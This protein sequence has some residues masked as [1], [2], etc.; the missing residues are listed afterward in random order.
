MGKKRKKKKETAEKIR[1]PILLY[2]TFT[3][4]PKKEKSCTQGTRDAYYPPTNTRASFTLYFSLV[5]L[6]VYT[7]KP[8]LN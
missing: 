6:H 7:L 3:C 2:R 4:P 1:N 5:L 8:D